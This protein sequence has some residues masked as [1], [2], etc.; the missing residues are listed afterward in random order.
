MLLNMSV[1]DGRDSAAEHLVVITDRWIQHGVLLE[2]HDRG[3]VLQIAARG[4]WLEPRRGTMLPVLPQLLR[5]R[6]AHCSAACL[7]LT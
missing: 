4:P 6:G 1:R 5:M 3:D 2:G 7:F